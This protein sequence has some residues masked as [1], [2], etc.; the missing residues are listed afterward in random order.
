MGTKNPKMVY[1]CSFS[2]FFL[3]IDKKKRGMRTNIWLSIHK[4]FLEKTYLTNESS[5]E[6]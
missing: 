4:H 2:F 1:F 3:N 5:A 6:N